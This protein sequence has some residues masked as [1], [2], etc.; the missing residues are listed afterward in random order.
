MEEDS[1]LLDEVVIVGYGVQ[2]K[3]DLTG[4]VASVSSEDIKRLST[5]DA[6]AALQ[7]K[8]AARSSP[9]PGKP[10]REALHDK[11]PA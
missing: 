10:L 9:P 7:G 1:K 4:A 5:T 3:S 2:R 8:A 11:S 6:G